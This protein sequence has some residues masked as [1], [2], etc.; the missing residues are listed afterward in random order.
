MKNNFNF[1]DFLKL[2]STFLWSPR[3]LPQAHTCPFPSLSVQS[4]EIQFLS[5]PPSFQG[6]FL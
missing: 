1:L 5:W 4:V 3:R 6:F 2:N